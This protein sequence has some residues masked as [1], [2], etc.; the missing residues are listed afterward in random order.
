M[1][2][3]GRITPGGVAVLYALGAALWIIVS[4]YLVTTGVDDPALQGRIEIGKGLVFVAVTS[5][6]LYLLL[7][8]LG[9]PAI[10]DSYFTT[11]T[12]RN[13][14]AVAAGVFLI[15]AIA[16]GLLVRQSEQQRQQRQR[17]QVADMAHDHARAIQRSIE[18]ALSATYALAALVRQGKGEIP[19]FE[20]TAQEMLRFYPGA[21]SLQL[22][23]G[24]I[25]R[26]VVPLDGNEKAIG[27]DLLQDPARNKEAFLARDTRK[28]TL[29]GRSI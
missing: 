29:A 1:P 14:L 7:G 12:S 15:A 5:L 20:A 3:F 2:T 17:A 21:G 11:A 24:G 23:P 19:D 6:L 28:L 4:G 25:V 10:E 8:R 16:S 22:A 26:R 18:H 9:M 27:H 13:P